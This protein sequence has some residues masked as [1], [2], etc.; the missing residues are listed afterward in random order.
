LVQG[1][2]LCHIGKLGTVESLA[3]A[4]P[5]VTVLHVLGILRLV[6]ELLDIV[7]TH[8]QVQRTADQEVVRCTILLDLVLEILHQ[9]LHLKEIMEEVVDMCI[10]DQK[11]HSFVAVVVAQAPQ[12]EMEQHLHLFPEMVEMGCPAL[13]YLGQ[14]QHLMEHLDHHQEGTLLAAEVGQLEHTRKTLTLPFLRT[15]SVQAARVE[16]EEGDQKGLH[17]FTVVILA[18]VVLLILVVVVVVVTSI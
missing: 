13:Q 18:E 7:R 12:A 11:S 16:P 17:M 9:Y 10:L 5:E 1:L 14:S 3:A 4:V 2:Q 6:V 15:M 8:P